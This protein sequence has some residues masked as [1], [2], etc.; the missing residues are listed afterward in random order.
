MMDVP[1]NPDYAGIVLNPPH[2]T[3]IDSF[4]CI[5]HALSRTYG[6][7]FYPAEQQLVFHAD[8]STVV[9]RI[10]DLEPEVRFYADIGLPALSEQVDVYR[11]ALESNLVRGASAVTIGVHGESARLVANG[12]FTPRD[13]A[14]ADV[15]EVASYKM[16]E[17]LFECVQHM[18]ARFTFF[19]E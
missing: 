12:V 6:G 1:H 4:L 18:R 8:H 3:V 14:D 17:Q 5:V 15:L 9:V 11:A 16:V 7:N 10:D 19:I 2:P 13:L